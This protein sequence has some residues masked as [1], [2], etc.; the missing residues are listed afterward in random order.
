MWIVFI[1]MF[2]CSSGRICI[3]RLSICR[4]VNGLVGV[5]VLVMLVLCSFRF[6]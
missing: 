5:V 4:L 3:D 1:C 6:S 2:L